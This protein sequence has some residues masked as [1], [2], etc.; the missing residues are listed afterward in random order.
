MALGCT[1]PMG[2]PDGTTVGSGA[3]VVH[4]DRAAI[5]SR[6]AVPVNRVRRLKGRVEAALLIRE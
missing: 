3:A 1:G 2:C 4:P 5:P 6:P